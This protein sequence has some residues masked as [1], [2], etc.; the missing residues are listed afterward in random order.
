M[1]EKKSGSRVTISGLESY[2]SEKLEVNN[3]LGSPLTIEPHTD[4]LCISLRAFASFFCVQYGEGIGSLR[5]GHQLEEK[6]R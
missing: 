6:K 2:F 1:A 5:C 4:T 3:Q